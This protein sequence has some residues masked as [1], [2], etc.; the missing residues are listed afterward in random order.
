[1]GKRPY[2]YMAMHSGIAKK[3]SWVNKIQSATA[4]LVPGLYAW[5]HLCPADPEL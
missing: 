5:E 2:T 4:V 1:V 3:A